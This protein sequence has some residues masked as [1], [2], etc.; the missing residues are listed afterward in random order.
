[1]LHLH[2]LEHQDGLAR[3]DL[4][5]LLDGDPA[6]PVEGTG[7]L[8]SPAYV[9]DLAVWI[10]AAVVSATLMWSRSP[11]GVLLSVSMLAF[12]LVEA[13]SVASDQWWGVRAD[14]THPELASLAA[15]PG[16]LVVAAVTAAALTWSL[17]HLDSGEA[18][19]R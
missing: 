6:R 12:Y 19:L 16:A 9:Q 17:K 10:P 7:L 3:V 1:M 8:T 4:P 15:V 2:G 13:L 11:R 18:D 5:A 14:D